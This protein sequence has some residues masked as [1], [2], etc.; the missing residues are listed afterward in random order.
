MKKNSELQIFDYNESDRQLGLKG[1]CKMYYNLFF[2][3]SRESYRIQAIF[4][5]EE[6]Q[7]KMLHCPHIDFTTGWSTVRVKR[8]ASFLPF[9]KCI[10]INF[11]T[12]L[13]GVIQFGPLVHLGRSQIKNVAV[14]TFRVLEGSGQNLQLKERCSPFLY[15]FA[16]IEMC[17][18]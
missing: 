16:Y 9:K 5:Q 13:G 2:E 7:L 8:K 1:G 4:T 6:K 18:R 15:F 14:S 11:L 12:S 17:Y 10:T 3:A